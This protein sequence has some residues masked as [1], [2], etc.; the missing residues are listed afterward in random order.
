MNAPAANPINDAYRRDGFYFPVPAMSAAEA[1][2]YR[3]KLEDYERSTGGPI[4]GEFRSDVH[5]LFTWAN[6]LV[7][8]P[9][10]LDA[11]EAVLGPDILCWAC[12]FS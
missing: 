10:I 4:A 7:H 8:H 12:S 2:A 1:A 6:E 11:V 3:A 9:R 5:L